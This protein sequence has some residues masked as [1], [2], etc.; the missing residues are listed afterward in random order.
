[1][2]NLQKDVLQFVKRVDRRKCNNRQ[3]VLLSLLLRDEMWIPRT[4]IRIPNVG[5]RLRDLRK[6]EFG[7]FGI[8]CATA[9]NLFGTGNYRPSEVTPQPTYYRIRPE[10]ITLDALKRAL[11]GVM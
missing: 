8:E 3:K 9:R 10:T 4:T 1:M 5:S 6:D 11:K 7:R 2:R